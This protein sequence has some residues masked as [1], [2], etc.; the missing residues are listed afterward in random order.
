MEQV[1][2][3]EYWTKKYPLI[4]TQIDDPDEEWVIHIRCDAANLNQHSY[5]E[6]LWEFIEN[7]PNR[8]AD[9]QMV[10]KREDF[11]KIR[12]TPREKWQLELLA[13]QNWYRTVSAYVRAK[14]LQVN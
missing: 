5:M 12:M 14:T 8:I 11:I 1:I 6:D 10:K 2:Y 9:V 13:K 3:I 7:L 4:I